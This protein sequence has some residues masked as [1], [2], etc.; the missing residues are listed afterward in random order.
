MNELEERNLTVLEFKKKHPRQYKYLLGYYGGIRI[1][2][3]AAA[4]CLYLRGAKPPTCAICGKP[5]SVDK[6][7]RNSS[8]S[9][10]CN[11]HSKTNPDTI[12]TRELLAANN[13]HGYTIVDVPEYASPSNYIKLH[14]HNHGDFS[15]PAANF[16][17]G[18]RCNK[19]YDRSTE[20]P[21]KVD[22]D[23]WLE[24]S[25]GHFGDFYD[26]S[27][28]SFN[29]VEKDM[30]T[31]GCP[32]HGD[33]EQRASTH[34]RGHGCPKCSTEKNAKQ[35]MHT[36][37]EFIEFANI[38]HSGKYTYLNTEY[39]GAR[40]TVLIECPIHGEFEQV[41][42][43]H[44]AGNGCQT[45]GADNPYS[46]SNAEFEIVMWLDS[47]GV[48]NIKHTDRSLGV[49]LDIYLADY[50]IAIEY[51]GIY[52]H[53]ANNTES[54]SKHRTRHLLKT[55]LCE[56]AGIQLFHINELEWKDPV[57]KEIWKSTLAHKLQLASRRIYA[58]KCDIVTVPSATARK[59]Y[60]E[61][62]LQG[63]ASGSDYI[64]LE[65][66]GELVS[67]AT[68]TKPRYR[69]DKESCI[70][71]LR[72]ATI[73]NTSVVGGFSKLI[74]HY[75]KDRTGTLLSYA[76]RRWSVGNVY[77]QCGFVLDD[78][79]N[80]GYYYTNNRQM[81][82][83]SKFQKHKLKDLLEIFDPNLSEAANMYANNYGRI[84]DCGHLVFEMKF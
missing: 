16:L 56:A 11:T 34:M 40:E 23:I 65:Y 46:K 37:E 77:S 51:D 19:C 60:D 47:I 7:S 29:R 50:N 43:Y 25:I 21:V 80:P 33:F 70:E 8:Y 44:L 75:C 5:L 3:K 15:Q 2:D 76:N 6:W 39:K 62:H 9:P 61:N 64:G 52:W 57:Q 13:P 54:E 4:V 27:K 66:Q 72:F 53:S 42:Y 36:T 79:S 67:V 49:E 74:K 82:H 30:I 12:V 22:H 20:I 35:L 31:I 84:W 58:R 28:V 32:D 63:F 68:F 83:R 69:E 81:W 45:C 41:A 59:F 38:K 26:Y 73:L 48:E 55:N 1:F 10:R 14:C 24:R 71:L 18:M 17:K 78:V